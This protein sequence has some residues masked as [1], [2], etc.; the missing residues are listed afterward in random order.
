MNPSNNRF[1][2]GPG[3]MVAAAFIGPGTVTTATLAGHGFGYDLLWAVLF[4]V[5]ATLVLQEMTLRLGIV[6]QMGLGTAIRQKIQQPIL[7]VMAASL[8]IGAI[9]IGNAA[10][11]TGNITGALLGLPP[12]TFSL[13]PYALNLWVL[14]VGGAAFGLLYAGKSQLI[15]GVLAGMVA[16]MALVFVLTAIMVRPDLSAMLNGLVVP[17]LPSKNTLIVIALVGTTIVPYNLFLHA[18]SVRTRWQ[19]AR[20]LREGRRDTFVSILIG[21]VITLAI[22]LT[23]AAAASDTPVKGLQDLA[24]QL[25]PLLGSWAPRVLGVGLFAAGVSS[26]ITAPLAAAYA[27]AGVLGW[28]IDLKAPR[29]RLIWMAVLGIG[30]AFA[31]RKFNPIPVILF[32][33]V[34]N[35]LLLPIIVGFLLW[36]MNDRT[37]LG[38]H[39]N[40]AAGNVLGGVVWLIALGLGMVSLG[41][42]F[43]WW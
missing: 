1:R 27:T 4:S 34:A 26:A 13:G 25:E 14:L 21:G 43:G 18:D 5:S 38:T 29:F 7:Y 35:G 16:L 39:A 15:A 10:Y 3:A 12:L 30:V 6:G 19:D 9:L 42:V 32:A 31:L 40:R 23:S 17:K 37:V 2:I 33:Q 22:V 36:V 8:V 11:E 28:E 20:S 41:K 24:A